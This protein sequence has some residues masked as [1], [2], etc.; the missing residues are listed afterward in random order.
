MTEPWYVSLTPSPGTPARARSRRRRWRQCCRNTR[1]A[2]A[3]CTRKRWKRTDGGRARPTRSTLPEHWPWRA[4]LLLVP[5]HLS[6]CM[7]PHNPR[8]VRNSD[9]PPSLGRQ[10][11]SRSVESTPLPVRLG[12]HP[13]ASN[14]RHSCSWR[15]RQRTLGTLMQRCSGWTALSL[16][17][18]AQ[19]RR[20]PPPS[21]TRTAMVSEAPRKEAF[22]P[23]ALTVTSSAS[24]IRTRGRGGR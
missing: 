2:S 14:R 18:D 10:P 5:P 12:P 11:S 19:R 15:A 16:S 7:A 3:A 9:S 6:I 8:A 1:L 21:A 24:R 17:R 20:S 4:C 13:D 22:G 23:L